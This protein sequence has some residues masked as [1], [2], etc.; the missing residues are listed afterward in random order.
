MAFMSNHLTYMTTFKLFWKIAKFQVCV[1]RERSISLFYFIYH[2]RIGSI[3]TTSI[4]ETPARQCASSRRK[5]P[6][7]NNSATAEKQ[8]SFENKNPG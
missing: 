3:K 5:H 8:G 1:K 6:L 2:F 4:S 7:S